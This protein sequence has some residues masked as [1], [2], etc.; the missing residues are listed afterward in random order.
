MHAPLSRPATRDRAA[1]FILL[2]MV[3]ACVVLQPATPLTLIPHTAALPMAG[4]ALLAALSL[5]G[6]LTDRPRLA[7]IGI[8][9]LQMT[10]FTLLGIVL[11]YALAAQSGALWDPRFA[12]WDR[13]LG[14]DWPALRAG[15]DEW[16]VLVWVLSLSYY[17]LVPQMIVAIVGLGA[18][19]RQDTLRLI[20]C[21]ALLAGF[22][23]IL[24]SGL[25]PATGNLFEAGDYD[26]L[27]P[28]VTAMTS[29]EV[30]RLRDGSLRA[31]DLG[32]L[33]G[34]VTFPSYHAALA[35]IFIRAFRDVPRLRMIGAIWA[36]LTIVAT[37]INGGHYLVDVLAGLALGWAS[38]P[39][40]AWLIRPGPARH[41]AHAVPAKALA[42][43]R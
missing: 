36:M 10:L 4:L 21:A 7:W 22:A 2:A 34:I 9:F 32:Q 41:P 40:A 18:C 11:S 15:L 28:A 39:V 27:W 14:L 30:L 13:A 5:W 42:P 26:H 31:L 12:A 23:T 3:I 38:L 16:P 8:A 1:W 25:T 35:L 24:L 33:M 19:E 17:S 20:V 43:S 6:Q 37:P 29:E